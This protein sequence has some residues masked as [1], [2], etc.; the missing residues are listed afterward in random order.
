[1]TTLDTPA[2]VR[3]VGAPGVLSFGADLGMG[4]PMDH[5]LRQCLIADGRRRH[6][7]GRT[8]AAANSYQALV[9]PRPYQVSGEPRGGAA[10][11]A[12]LLS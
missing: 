12:R 9:E 10:R 6:P 3:A 8:T 11:V 4:R 1:M 5:V 2:G 7:G